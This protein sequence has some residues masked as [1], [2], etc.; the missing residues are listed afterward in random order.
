MSIID[1]MQTARNRAARWAEL[2]M[3]DRVKSRRLV[4]AGFPGQIDEARALAGQL[5]E[6]PGIRESL[7]M[8]I[9]AEAQHCWTLLSWE[10]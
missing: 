10:H 7:A 9:R 2:T 1:Q 3:E 8:L 5:T 4:T 6:D